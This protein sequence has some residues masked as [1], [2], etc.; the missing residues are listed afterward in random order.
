[1]TNEQMQPN[2]FARWANARKMFSYI[3]TN[4]HAG[5]IVVVAS[6]TTAT[7]YDRRHVKMFKVTKTG[8][9]VQHG[10]RWDCINFCAIKAF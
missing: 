1:M 6:M 9:F 7:K 10:K 8:V 4:L 2:R 3:M 5:K